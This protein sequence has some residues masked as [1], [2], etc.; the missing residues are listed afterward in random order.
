MNHE[1]IAAQN[2]PERYLMGKL[3]SDESARFEEHFVDCPDCLDRLESAERFRAA[4][5]PLAGE[6]VRSPFGRPGWPHSAW[7]VAAALVLAVG[8][9]VFLALRGRSLQ[10][11][12]ART[13]IASFDWQ[14][15][16]EK[17]RAAAKTST[18]PGPAGQAV[19]AGPLVASI[20]YL[21]TT[22]GGEP[23]TSEPANRVTVTPDSHW[24]ALSLEDELPPEFQNLR[25]SLQ[26]PAGEDVWQQTGLRA[27]AHQVLSLILPSDMLHRGNY[28]LTLEGLASTGRYLPVGR[29]RFRVLTP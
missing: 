17:E 1:E 5:K 6:I 8:V 14:H 9:S 21:N 22:R 13:R 23:E 16:Y 10:Q 19:P 20:F 15:R 28:V 11:E 4:L 27:T 29:Y 24:I 12:L 25:A 18:G 2:I 26:G 7:L 3:S